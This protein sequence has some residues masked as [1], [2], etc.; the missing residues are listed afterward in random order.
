MN[1]EQCEKLVKLI[2]SL[3]TLDQLAIAMTL[4]MTL[5]DTTREAADS[6]LIERLKWFDNLYRKG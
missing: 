5:D 1:E 6:A 3:E 4:V 2:L